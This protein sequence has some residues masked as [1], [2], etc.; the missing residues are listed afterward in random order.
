MTQRKAAV[1][2]GLLWV[3]SM[4]AAFWVGQAWVPVD[5]RIAN[6]MVT[7]DAGGQ[8]SSSGSRSLGTLFPTEEGEGVWSESQGGGG[9]SAL[10]AFSR[11][12]GAPGDSAL[13]DEALMQLGRLNPADISSA[14]DMLSKL[15]EGRRRNAM[16]FEL[17]QRWGKSDPAAAL[18]YAGN[19]ESMRLRYQALERVLSGWATQDPVAAMAWLDEHSGSESLR[20]FQRQFMAIV[21][22]Y[23]EKDPVGAFN[24][25]LNL[26]ENLR[27]DRQMKAMALNRSI[28]S[29]LAKGEV[30]TAMNLVQ[31]LPEGNIRNQALNQ[32]VGEWARQDPQAAL[33]WTEALSN[34]GDQRMLRRSLMR[35]WAETDPQSAANWLAQQNVPESD[36]AGLVTGLIARWSEYDTEASAQ[37]LNQMPPSPEIDRAVAVYTAQVAADDP[38]GAMSWAVSITD[39]NLRNRLMS[40]VASE[41]K[42]ADPES[43][44]RY[45]QDANLDPAVK[46]MLQNT[47]AGGGRRGFGGFGGGGFGGGGF[48]G[49]PPAP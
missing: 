11:L 28:E 15:P 46:E 5:V 35:S 37:W 8:S 25:A 7:G 19:V 23:A 24:Y 13:W 14:L 31:N 3:G 1:G 39:E 10:G 20:T 12:A 26:P 32:F 18:E 42:E 43:F 17:L 2:I 45:L 9:G 29:L 30:Q 4:A 48:G 34:E 6:R 38:E 36:M 49:P 44:N 33:K 21:N 27:S 40:R 22:G 41:W 47:R 16:M